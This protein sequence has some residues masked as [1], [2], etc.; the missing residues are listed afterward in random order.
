MSVVVMRSSPEGRR[1]WPVTSPFER[2]D[3]VAQPVGEFDHLLAAGG[4][5]IAAASAFEQ[6]RA[7]VLLDLA[8]PP[9]H[10]GVVDAKLFGRAGQ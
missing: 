6:A 9:E 8:E 5:R 10:G 2:D 4:E 7:E 1:S 3:V